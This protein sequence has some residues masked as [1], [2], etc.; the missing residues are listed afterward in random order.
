MID[1]LHAGTT[2]LSIAGI[3]QIVASGDLGRL[4]ISVPGEGKIDA[5]AARASAINVDFGGQGSVAAMVYGPATG[6]LTGKGAIA[7]GGRPI[8]S[9]R[10]AGRGRVICPSA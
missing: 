8:C 1:G 9:V 2:N 10:N 4:T 7:I 6:G 5:K 3:G